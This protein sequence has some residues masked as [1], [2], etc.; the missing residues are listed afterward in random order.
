M[1]QF[2]LA[3]FGVFWVVFLLSGLLILLCFW[4]IYISSFML[5]WEK[6]IEKN[7]SPAKQRCFIIWTSIIVLCRSVSL[8]V[9]LRREILFGN[10]L[11]FVQKYLIAK[12]THF[13]AF[14]GA[15]EGLPS[16]FEDAIPLHL[17]R[18]LRLLRFFVSL[19]IF[20]IPSSLA[21]RNFFGRGFPV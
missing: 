16:Y 13:P 5:W 15:M 18:Y 2:C 21:A 14:P 3:L 19:F 20:L 17:L 12:S 4:T 7:F 8:S 11:I 9:C 1:K 10:L 6:I